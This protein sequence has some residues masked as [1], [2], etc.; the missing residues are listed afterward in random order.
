MNTEVPSSTAAIVKQPGTAAAA[1]KQKFND[2]YKLGKEVRLVLCVRT[3]V[4]EVC[5]SMSS[6][7]IRPFD[8]SGRVL[9]LLSK[10]GQKKGR[11]KALPSKL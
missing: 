11:E 6:S 4:A 5:L 7:H 1:G 8:S 9:S 2:V 3:A 10:R